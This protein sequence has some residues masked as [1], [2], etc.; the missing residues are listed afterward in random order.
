MSSE[1]LDLQRSS[2]TRQRRCRTGC[3]KCRARRRKC[4]EAKPR[5]QNCVAKNFECRYGTPLTFLAKNNFTI[6]EEPGQSKG[7]GTAR[8]KYASLEAVADSSSRSEHNDVPDSQIRDE[9]LPKGAS[10]S[11][12][13]ARTGDVH[14]VQSTAVT[15][16][17]Q[18][19]D[20]PELTGGDS[21]E[22]ALYGLLALGRSAASPSAPTVVTA[23]PLDPSFADLHSPIQSLFDRIPV[24]PDRDVH[25]SFDES[26]PTQPTIHQDLTSLYLPPLRTLELLKYF[27]YEIA[28]ML[29]M[30]DRDQTFGLVVPRLAM[31]SHPVLLVLLMLSSSSSIRGVESSKAGSSEE[32]LKMLA[33]IYDTKQGEESNTRHALVASVLYILLGFISDFSSACRNGVLQTSS[34]WNPSDLVEFSRPGRLETS[35]YFLSLRLELSVCLMRSEAPRLP[36]IPLSTINHLPQKSDTVLPYAYQGLL[37]CAEVLS[38]CWGRAEESATMTRLPLATRWYLLFEKLEGWYNLR[39]GELLPLVELDPGQVPGSVDRHFPT[40][41]FSTAAGVFANQMHHTAMFLLLLHKPRNLRLQSTPWHTSPLWHS[42]RVCGI[43]LN[44]NRRESWDP[45]LLSSLLLVAR[46]MTHESQQRALSEGFARIQNLTGFQISE[47][48]EALRSTWSYSAD[49]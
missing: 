22:S 26:S 6:V 17:H 36:L 25:A 42:E 39:P 47:T 31:V 12:T 27:R 21:Y 8:P 30:M 40:I 49:I 28:P 4:D 9:S 16:S 19:G 45:C 1:A 3:L 29:D 48:V 14:V 33:I 23:P 24:L 11:S 13:S 2:A 20:H 10:L 37:M 15:E 34:P 35:L 18:H 44:N 43:A 5:C 32:E 46:R 7:L 38:L 41:S